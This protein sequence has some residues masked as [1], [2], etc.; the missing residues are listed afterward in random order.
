MA[1]AERG[2]WERAWLACGCAVWVVPGVQQSYLVTHP[3]W[4]PC[5]IMPATTT[6]QAREALFV[7]AGAELARRP[8][9]GQLTAALARLVRAEEDAP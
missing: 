3:G 7:W 1:R 9:A 4:P 2:P 5:A 8:G 6:A